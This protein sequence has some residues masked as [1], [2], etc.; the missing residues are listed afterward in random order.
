M[1]KLKFYQF[2]RDIPDFRRLRVGDVLIYRYSTRT[3]CN[4]II[5]GNYLRFKGF[6]AS[7]DKFSTIMVD[8]SWITDREVFKVDVENCKGAIEIWRLAD[9]ET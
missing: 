2:V 7:N 8:L 9:D 3:E 1:K 4:F 5:G 6:L